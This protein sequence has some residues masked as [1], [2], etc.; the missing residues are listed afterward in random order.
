MRFI[1]VSLLAC[2]TLLYAQENTYQVKIVNITK[3][4]IISPPV[5]AAHH[6]DLHIFTVGEP[7][8]ETV[9]MMAEDG[10]AGP[11]RDE[12]AASDLVNEAV[13]ADGPLMPGQAVTLQITTDGRLNRISVL[14]MLVTTND[15]FFGL[16]GVLAP[17]RNFKRG[18]AAPS[19]IH[20]ANAYDAG[21]EYNSE[22]C[23]T[24]PGPPCGNGG[25]RDT[26][27][28][29]GYVYPHPGLHGEGDISLSGYNWAGAVVK[30]KI[31]RIP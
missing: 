13:A 9:S 22:D 17:A 12:L 20:F 6:P 18:G 27:N 25:V 4:Q 29:E 1:L 19:S 23:G 7:A 11:L 14:G 8:W 10:M 3:G 2:C 16:D 30:I 31:T 28:A 15:A 21:T 24:I 5:V 26:E